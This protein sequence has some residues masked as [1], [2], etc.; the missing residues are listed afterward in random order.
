LSKPKEPAFLRII[1]HLIFLKTI[2]TIIIYSN[3]NCGYRIST[4]NSIESFWRIYLSFVFV[5]SAHIDYI[6][7]QE[8]KFKIAIQIFVFRSIGKNAHSRHTIYFFP[9]SNK[10]IIF[11]LNEVIRYRYEILNLIF[12]SLQVLVT[13]LVFFS[14]SFQII[15]S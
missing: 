1:T 6:S 3:V 11:H 14:F 4:T 13:R 15:Y 8:W 7:I 2:I 5:I 12:Y 10:S 9:L